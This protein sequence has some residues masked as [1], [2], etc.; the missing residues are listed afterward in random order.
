MTLLPCI[1]WGMRTTKITKQCELCGKTY[2]T[3][4]PSQRFCSVSCAKKTPRGVKYQHIVSKCEW[5]GSE[6]TPKIYSQRFCSAQCSQRAYQ[7]R[8]KAKRDGLFD[9]IKCP[10]VAHYRPKGSRSKTSLDEVRELYGL[11][12]LKPEQV[13]CYVCGEK[14]KSWDKTKNKRCPSCSNNEELENIVSSGYFK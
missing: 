1:L 14:F 9:D 7:Q 8:V 4:K 6:Y 10:A 5:C 11:K 3:T 12:P 2:E 13:T